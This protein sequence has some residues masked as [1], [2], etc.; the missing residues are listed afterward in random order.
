MQEEF[1]CV[2]DDVVCMIVEC[3]NIFC[4]DIYGVCS[5]YGDFSCQVDKL[6]F[7]FCCV[8]VCQV[9]GSEELV[10]CFFDKGIVSEIIYCLGNCVLGFVVMIG[11]CLI[12]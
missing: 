8:E 10:C 12:G 2:S 4:V 6:K 9:V 5:F 3:F 11:E 7:K 1:G